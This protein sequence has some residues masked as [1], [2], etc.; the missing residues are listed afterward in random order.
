VTALFEHALA[1]MEDLFEVLAGCVPPRWFA[2]DG[3]LGRMRLS[4]AS[5]RLTCAGRAQCV[6]VVS[7]EQAGSGRSHLQ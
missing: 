7:T 3:W 6:N 4:H 5:R 1:E 2:R